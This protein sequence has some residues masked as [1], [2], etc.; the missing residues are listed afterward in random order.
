MSVFVFPS[1]TDTFGLVLLEAMASGVPV[2]ATPE[3]GA[4]V[5]IEDGRTG[6][7]T[8]NFPYSLIELMQNH[9]LRARMS[10]A[11][12]RFVEPKSWCGV[13]QELY[14]S[15]EEGLRIVSSGPA[16]RTS[17]TLRNRN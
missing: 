8:E 7:L 2:I 13:F 12:R 4:R 11:A 10:L 16:L 6:L 17:V 9:D 3:T 1:R 5:G 15:Y 14:E